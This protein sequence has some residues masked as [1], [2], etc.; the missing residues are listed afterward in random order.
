MKK[1]MLL[2]ILTSVCSLSIAKM[3]TYTIIWGG[4]VDDTA[5]TLKDAKNKEIHAYCLNKCG[6]WFEPSTEHEGETLIT[7][8]KGKKVLVEFSYENN[9]DRIAGP[10]ADEK[11]YFIKKIK[12]VHK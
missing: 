5:L 9:K 6:D 7:K 8:Y 10:G 12:L 3:Q 1:I 11:L 4:G 2:A